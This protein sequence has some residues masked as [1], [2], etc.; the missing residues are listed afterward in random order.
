[1]YV[2]SYSNITI[3][4]ICLFIGNMNVRLSVDNDGVGDD[5]FVY[6]VYSP[7]C[8]QWVEHTLMCK[9]CKWKL[10]CTTYDL[11]AIPGRPKIVEQLRLCDAASKIIVVLARDAFTEDNFLHE[12]LQIIS[13]EQAK[14]IPILCGVSEDQLQGNIVY[15]SIVTYVSIQHSDNHFDDRLQQ[16]L[17][18]H[19]S[20]D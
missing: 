1:M 10:H 9:L 3:V 18:N 11:S 8:E 6:V 13:S 16:A 17:S 5:D 12:V 15:R 14:V 7:Q 19:L 20:I 2:S 4:A